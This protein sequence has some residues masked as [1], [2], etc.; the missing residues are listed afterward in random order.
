MASCKARFM[1]N[2][3]GCNNPFTTTM[4]QNFA[5]KHYMQKRINAFHFAPKSI[6]HETQTLDTEFQ[7]RVPFA[8]WELLGYHLNPL[9][10]A[11][12]A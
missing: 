12:L 10:L 4:T 6:F 7:I 2:F 8:I 3:I 9:T 5:E 11:K 1:L